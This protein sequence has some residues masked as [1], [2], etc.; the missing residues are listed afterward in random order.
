MKKCIR[1]GYR[2]KEN[3]KFCPECG[4]KMTELYAEQNNSNVN[5]TKIINCP[6]CGKQNSGD[7][8]FCI[9]C[10]AKLNDLNLKTKAKIIDQKSKNRKKVFLGITI[11]VTFLIILSVFIAVFFPKIQMAVL[12]ESG[13]YFYQE[14]KNISSLFEA[15]TISDLRHPDS[16][17]ARSVIEADY[18]GDEFVSELLNSMQATASVDYDAQTA[19][20]KS[21]ASLEASGNT[22][23]VLN[24]NYTDSKFIIGS[25]FSDST[26][27]F[28]N[29]LLNNRSTD[30]H[31]VTYSNQQNNSN[32]YGAYS[33]IFDCL[34]QIDSKELLK[35]LSNI[36]TNYIDTK[37]VRSDTYIR[38]ESAEIVTFSFSGE[39]LDSI[40]NEFFEEISNNENLAPVADSILKIFNNDMDLNDFK[41][42]LAENEIVSNSIEKLV[43]SYAYDSRGKIIFREYEVD[44]GSYSAKGQIYTTYE[45]SNINTLEAEFIPDSDLSESINV[46]MQ[47][48]QNNGE[49][50]IS[51]YYDDGY[52]NFTLS[53]NNMHSEKCNGVPVLLGQCKFSYSSD[54][55]SVLS[56]NISADNLNNKYNISINGDIAYGGSFGGTISTSLSTD[57]D[58]TGAALP[59]NYET[60]IEEYIY[61]LFEDIGSKV[62][63]YVEDNYYYY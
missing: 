9:N 35:V 21:S 5:K 3:V 16:Y 30:D 20:V 48:E 51:L 26:L 62:M 37:A 50:N 54:D 27:V 40:I 63:E 44:Y 39:E 29:P 55:E 52:N 24:G 53:V 1:C 34:S 41:E 42:S 36:S 10:G 25:D 60:N 28:D 56:L 59:N 12:G 47:K 38:T 49:M 6:K 19:T 15:E 2:T 58:V 32:N 17:S 46:S 22:L 14:S 8:K 23:F 33:R 11:P 13:Y 57:S 45:K 43:F 18:S 4:Y 31:S 61:N 7:V